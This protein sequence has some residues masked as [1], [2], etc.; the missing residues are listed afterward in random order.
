LK[1]TFI[2]RKSTQRVKE[3]SFLKN[4]AEKNFLE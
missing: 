3:Q 2:M 4:C 1:F